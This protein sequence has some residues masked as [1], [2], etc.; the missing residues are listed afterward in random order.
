MKLKIDVL[1]FEACPNHLPVV[2]RIAEVLQEEACDAQ[3]CEVLVPDVEAAQSMSFLGSPTVRIN[4]VDIEPAA[5][6]SQDFGF[7]CRWYSG[8]IPSRELIRDAVRF[9]QKNGGSQ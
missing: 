6:N 9:V 7:M 5:R 3:V 2:Q 8:G 4:G 1:Y